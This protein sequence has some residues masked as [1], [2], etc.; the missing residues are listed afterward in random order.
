MSPLL[1]LGIVVEGVLMFAMVNAPIVVVDGGNHIDYSV[2]LGFGGLIT[3]LYV[4]A[5]CGALLLSSDRVAVIHSGVNLIAVAALAAGDGGHFFVVPLG[6]RD[7]HRHRDP[8]ATN[9]RAAAGR[10]G[11]LRGLIGGPAAAQRPKSTKS[12]FTSLTVVHPMSANVLF[13]SEENISRTRST[14][15]SPAAPSPYR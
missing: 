4:V 8:L 15:A 6:R 9:S 13:M 3:V 2:S 7:E 11:A 1:G 14:P 5:T 12:R 10:G